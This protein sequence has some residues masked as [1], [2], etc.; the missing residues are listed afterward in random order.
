MTP[1]EIVEA[2][3]YTLKGAINSDQSTA[4]WKNRFMAEL[5]EEIRVLKKENEKFKALQS[6]GL[7]RIEG[8]NS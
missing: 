4:D 2:T 6:H 1:Q 5:V 8:E 3:L 7:P